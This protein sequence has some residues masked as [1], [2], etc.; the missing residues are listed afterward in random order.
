MSLYVSQISCQ[1]L[2]ENILEW[3]GDDGVYNCNEILV[4]DLLGVVLCVGNVESSP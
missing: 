3:R 1:V 2:I 4:D